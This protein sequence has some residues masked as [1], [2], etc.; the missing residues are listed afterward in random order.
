MKL[1]MPKWCIIHDWLYNAPAPK[2]GEWYRE[3]IKCGKRQ[4]ATYDMAYGETIWQKG[5][6]EGSVRN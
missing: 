4:H 1:K 5:W 2:D 3:C 6:K